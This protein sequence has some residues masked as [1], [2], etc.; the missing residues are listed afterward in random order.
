MNIDSRRIDPLFQE[1]D[2]LNSP[3]CA[4]AVIRNEQ[5]VHGR[6]YGMADLEHGIAI[7]TSSVFDIGS[8][9][10]QFTALCAL[11]LARRNVINLGEAIQRW[12]PEIPV[13]EKPVTV[14]HLIHHTSGLRDYLVLMDLAGLRTENE[15]PEEQ[16]TAWIGRQKALNFLPGEEYLYC[17]SGYYL[18]SLIVKRASG[19]TLRQFA[20]ENIFQP[21]G[22][23][24]THFH[25]DFTEIVPARAVGYGKKSEADFCIDMSIFDVVGDGAVYTTV[26]DLLLWDSNFYHNKLD[27]GGPGLIEQM[28]TPG[29][30]NNGKEQDYAYGLMVGTYRGLRT[31]RHGGSWA[32]YRAEILRFPDQHF[33]VICLANMREFQPGVLARKIADLCLENDFTEAPLETASGSVPTVQIP[34]KTLQMY[35][36]RYFCEPNASALEIE[37]VNEKLFLEFYRFRLELEAT[38]KTSF[39]TVKGPYSVILNFSG[40]EVKFKLEGQ[41]EADVFVKTNPPA[42]DETKLMEYSGQYVSDELGVTYAVK[43]DPN[44]LILVRAD[45]SE[46]EIKALQEDLFFCGYLLMRFIRGADRKVSSFEVGAGRVKNILFSRSNV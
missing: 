28:Q 4:L 24:H 40:D 12:V 42:L 5:I 36:G 16:V 30:F 9:S 11:I 18:L 1:W 25:D 20:H 10:K 46:N 23:T 2:K 35:S 38:S 22:M 39:R 14:R 31:V 21:L 8:V 45:A 27:G 44:G 33:S 37:F 29:R 43:A 3:G 15:Y 26:E 13:Y 17:N 32:G 34:G 19:K 7:S 6:G 41:V